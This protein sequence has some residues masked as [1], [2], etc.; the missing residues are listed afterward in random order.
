[1]RSDEV[2]LR[3][4]PDVQLYTTKESQL[5]HCQTHKSSQNIRKQSPTIYHHLAAP[6]QHERLVT[7]TPHVT[8]KQVITTLTLYTRK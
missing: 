7:T 4:S 2:L 1:M 8:Q 6:T 5:R 3:M